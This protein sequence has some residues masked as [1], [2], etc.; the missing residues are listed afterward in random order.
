MAYG[1]ALD[2]KLRQAAGLIDAGQKKEARRL[3]REILTTD[4]NNLSAWELLWRA[5]YSVKEELIC[6]NHILAINPSHGAAKRR[7][8]DIRLRGDAASST[9]ELFDTT[10]LIQA[11]SSQPLPARKPPPRR[12]KKSQS[13]LALFLLFLFFPTLC[14]SIFGLIFYR[15]GYLDSFLFASSLT[16]TAIAD[17]NATCQALIEKAMQAS[18]SY[19]NEVGANKACYGN[20]TLKAD[21]APDATG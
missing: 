20:D 18:G 12:R 15:A 6:L 3:L 7:M 19:C 9:G 5:A 11:T 8:D 14:A 10:P 17:R 4:G 1:N 2:L 16:A 21:L 13:N